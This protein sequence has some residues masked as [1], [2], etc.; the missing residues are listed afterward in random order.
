MFKI[1]SAPDRSKP[2]KRRFFAVITDELAVNKH[3]G[4]VGRLLIYEPTMQHAVAQ[5]KQWKREYPA[6]RTR[7]V[8]LNRGDIPVRHYVDLRLH[9]VPQDARNMFGEY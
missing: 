2:V 7:A 3:S 1:V 9:M 8:E 5:Q 4:V 6:V